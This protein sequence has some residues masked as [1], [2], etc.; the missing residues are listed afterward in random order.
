MAGGVGGVD[1]GDGD[2]GEGAE[3]V[4]FEEVGASTSNEEGGGRVKAKWVG[5]TSVMER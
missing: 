5:S 1:G 4:G 3:D 2:V